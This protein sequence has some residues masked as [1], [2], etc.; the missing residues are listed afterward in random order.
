MKIRVYNIQYDTDGETVELPPE[1]FFIVDK[2]CV[3]SE[4]VADMIS[5]KTG[6]C[7]LGYDWNIIEDK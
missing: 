4:D 1:L 5:D 2:D 3:L 6:W 7:I